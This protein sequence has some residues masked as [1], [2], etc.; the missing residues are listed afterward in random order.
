MGNSLKNKLVFAAATA[1][2]LSATACGSSA[3]EQRSD[4][5]TSA[6]PGAGG[7]ASCGSHGSAG[8]ASCGGQGSGGA[9]ESTG[10]SAGGEASCGA[11]SCASGTS[12]S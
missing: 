7:Q 9:T 6:Q 12:G 1:L 5:T 11:G 8:E 2:G 3:A 4:S 10:D